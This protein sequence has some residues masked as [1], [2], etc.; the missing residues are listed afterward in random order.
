MITRVD[1]L[2]LE[3]LKEFL[4]G[5]GATS[6]QIMQPELEECKITSKIISPAGVSINGNIMT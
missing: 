1:L 4:V 2:L 5:F 3:L 6:S